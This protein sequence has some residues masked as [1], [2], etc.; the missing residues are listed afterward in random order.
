MSGYSKC[1]HP[2]T[3][4]NFTPT[5]Y[6]EEDVVVLTIRMSCKT[7]GAQFQFRGLSDYPS[8]ETPWVSDDGLI[9]ALP[10]TEVSERHLLS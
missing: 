3:A 6:E 1:R 7:C 10:M 4:V 5:H 9:A 2:E 8:P